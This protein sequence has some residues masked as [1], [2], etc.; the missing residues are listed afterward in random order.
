M[1]K[2]QGGERVLDLTQNVCASA[3]TAVKETL[4]LKVGS[5]VALLVGSLIWTA[6]RLPQTAYRLDRSGPDSSRIPLCDLRLM[7][8]CLQVIRVHC[9]YLETLLHG[10]P[11]SRSN[12]LVSSLAR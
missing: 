6:L 5:C 12:R 3:R 4:L 1:Q 7:Q 10:D 9:A 8:A 11:P 2:L